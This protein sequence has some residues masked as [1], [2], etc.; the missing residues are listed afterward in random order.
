VIEL[1]YSRKDLPWP[2]ALTEVSLS[3]DG[4]SVVVITAHIPNGARNGWDKIDTFKVLNELARQAKGTPCIVTG[5]FNEPQYTPLRDGHILTW[6]QEKNCPD[7]WEKWTFR[8]RTGTG[9]EWD[10]AVRWLFEGETEHG[11]RH[12]YWEAHGRG[13]MD[14]S[15]VT[16]GQPQWFDHIFVS[17]DFGVGQCEYVHEVRGPDLSDHSA[18]PASLIF[19]RKHSR[20]A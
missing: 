10:K 15:H 6:G 12:A 7:Y 16:H 9:K 11:L 17:A 19:N 14:V 20:S 2:Q 8:G 1:G 5:D 18:L 13:K 4:R 3:V